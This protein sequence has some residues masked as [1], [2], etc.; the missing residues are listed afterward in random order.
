MTVNDFTVPPVEDYEVP[1]NREF[2]G[3]FLAG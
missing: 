2:S 1:E 3:K